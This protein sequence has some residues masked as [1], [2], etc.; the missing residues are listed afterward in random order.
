MCESCV[1]GKHMRIYFPKG[2]PWK[3]KEVLGLLHINICGP[4]K[5]VSTRG[6]KYFI[7]F[8]NEYTRKGCVYLLYEKL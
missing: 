8:I 2:K 6:T 5:P 1:V 7:S 4:L 3:V